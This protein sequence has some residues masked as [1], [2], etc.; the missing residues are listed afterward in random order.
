MAVADRTV[1]AAV[2]AIPLRPS[3]WQKVRAGLAILLRSKVALVG[4]VLVGF[5]VIVA[6]FADDCIVQP[7][8]WVGS[9]G[10]KPTP[11][12]AVYSPDQST[13]KGMSA[14]GPGHWLGTDR[15]G[16]DLW[17]R[18]AYG[19]RIILTLAPLGVGA[20]H[21]R[22]GIAWALLDECERLMDQP[23]VRLRV[24]RSNTGA[25]RLYQ[26]AGYIQTGVERR[27]P[28]SSVLA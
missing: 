7:A 22:K 8:C 27:M 1:G 5:W 17:A 24:R 16:R 6:A 12:L 13:G 9:K 3:R 25:I 21:R 28:L 23:V 10:Y 18:L 15:N 4:L 14:P 19:A 2:P 11:W 20:A 26:Q